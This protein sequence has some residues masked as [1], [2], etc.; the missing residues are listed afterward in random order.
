MI[1]KNTIV[2]F[3]A[4]KSSFEKVKQRSTESQP[5]QWMS[6]PMRWALAKSKDT[7]MSI[8]PINSPFAQNSYLVN[9]MNK[10]LFN[11]KKSPAECKSNGDVSK[12]VS[13]NWST[14]A[15]RRNWWKRG[16]RSIT[17]TFTFSIDWVN[18]K[19]DGSTSNTSDSL[20]PST[21]SKRKPK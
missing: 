10:H 12:I 6:K 9:A 14:M 3:S 21:N 8:H 19:H 2:F 5:V 20:R 13:L 7:F 15:W 16:E 1:G 11:W 17:L 4:W 18:W